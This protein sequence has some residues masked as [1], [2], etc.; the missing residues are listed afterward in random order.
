MD[1]V[2]ALAVKSLAGTGE[3]LSRKNPP[4]V[5]LAELPAHVQWNRPLEEPVHH[6]Q[7]A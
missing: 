1:G 7:P 2:A 5:P 3:V 4:V 6:A